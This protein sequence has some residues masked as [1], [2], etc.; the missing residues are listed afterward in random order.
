MSEGIDTAG[1]SPLKGALEWVV[2]IAAAVGCAVLIRTFLA[3]PYEVPSSSMVDTIEVGDRVL[4]EKVTCSNPEA[5]D[6]VTFKDPE[7]SSTT[8]IKRV[9]ATEGQVVDIHDGNLYI[10]GVEQVESYVE[11]KRTDP[12]TQHSSALASSISY[13]YTVPDG[14]IWVMGDNRTNSLD[15]RYFGAVPTSSV[16]GKAMFVFWPLNDIK[17]L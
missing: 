6:V 4:A 16:T 14:C 15:S 1:H 2:I 8:L 7:D 3:E 10:D 5:G 17:G 12:I 9:L 11:G 13:P